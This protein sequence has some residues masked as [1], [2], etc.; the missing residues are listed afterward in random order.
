MRNEFEKQIVYLANNLSEAT[1]RNIL[2][3]YNKE[4]GKALTK[5]TEIEYSALCGRIGLIIAQ[6]TN[7][8]RDA[9][10]EFAM[11]NQF[12]AIERIIINGKGFFFMLFVY[13]LTKLEKINK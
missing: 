8:K 6:K 11:K 7:G 12:G 4:F 2:T 13:L 5:L 1:E 3:V 9:I 10:S